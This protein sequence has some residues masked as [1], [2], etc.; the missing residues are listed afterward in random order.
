[1]VLTLISM[2]IGIVVL[3]GIITFLIVAAVMLN[4]RYGVGA[5]FA[6]I[7]CVLLAPLVF[8]MLAWVTVAPMRMDRES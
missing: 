4:K 5:A 2:L 8:A 3:L 6:F 7:G 1:M